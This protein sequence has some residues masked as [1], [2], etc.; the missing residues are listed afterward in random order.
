MLT[1]LLL[2]STVL[3]AS[4]APAGS[5]PRTVAIIP[6]IASGERATNATVLN[7]ALEANLV[8]HG[9]E[10]KSGDPVALAVRETVGDANVVPN[11][12]AL[13]QIRK[14]LGVS[15]L[16]YPRLL[17]VG[18]SS[19]RDVTEGGIIFQANVLL[20]VM[21][22]AGASSGLM[23]TFQVGQVFRPAAGSPTITLN[24]DDADEAAA[25]LLEGFYTKVRV[26]T[27]KSR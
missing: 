26:S 27:H 4:P 20:N 10:V 23:H 6:I 17:T 7:R 5:L 18:V 22:D 19:R 16:V 12:D 8:R 2:A 11:Q 9:Y 25:S 21:T 24:A 3:A 14:K 15:Y 13:S 1:P